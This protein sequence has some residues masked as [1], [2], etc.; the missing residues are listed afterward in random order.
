VKNLCTIRRHDLRGVHSAPYYMPDQ[1][2][3]DKVR[4]RRMQYVHARYMCDLN[5]DTLLI[6]IE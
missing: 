4:L 5:Y 3:Y 6:T 2:L 1:L